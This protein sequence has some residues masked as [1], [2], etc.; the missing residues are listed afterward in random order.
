MSRPCPFHRSIRR[1]LRNR[2]GRA[3]HGR[4]TANQT[5]RLITKACPDCRKETR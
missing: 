2:L 4:R 3:H 1:T 5:I